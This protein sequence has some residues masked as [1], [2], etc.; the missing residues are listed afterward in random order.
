MTT[1]VF[2]ERAGGHDGARILIVDDDEFIRLFLRG[3]LEGGAYQVFEAQEGQQALEHVRSHP[4]GVDLLITDLNMPGLTGRALVQTLRGE[5]HTLPIIVLSG[6][7]DVNIAIGVIHDGADDYLLKDENMAETVF[8]AVKKALDTAW[9]TRENQQL[10][11][12][13]QES[14]RELEAELVCRQQNEAQIRRDYESKT[15]ISRLLEAAMTDLALEQQLEAM[16]DVVLSVP[17]FDLQKRGAVFLVEERTGDLVLKAAQG[18]TKAQ[19]AGCARLSSGQWG[20]SACRHALAEG[21]PLFVGHD[22]MGPGKNCSGITDC[23]RYIVPIRLPHQVL[24]V[25]KLYLAIDHPIHPEEEPFLRSVA[26]TLASVLERKRLEEAIKQRAEY[27]PLTGFA[28]R[29]LFY[30]RLTQAI[31]TAQRTDKDL[32]LMFID[33]DRFKQ[34]NDTLGHEAGDRLL[35]EALTTARSPG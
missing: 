26:S 24:G 18:L 35:Q 21:R 29:A 28:N 20:E 34:V 6:N 23:G 31:L 32:V 17:W 30:D 5:G 15:A 7:D 10:L 4:L 3:A 13:L 27:D 33:L 16:L 22:E 19:R 1:P 25:V 14:N 11:K 9:M 12:A 8:F 2:V